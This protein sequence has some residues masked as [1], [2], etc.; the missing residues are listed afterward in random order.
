MYSINGIPLDNTTY[1]WSLLR[2]GTNPFAGIT[3]ERTE[4]KVPGYDGYFMGPSTRSEKIIVLRV[5][6]P[7]AGLEPL[8]ALVD[9]QSGVLSRTEDPSRVAAF[10]LSSALPD[11]EFPED[12]TVYLTITLIVPGGAWRDSAAVLTGPTTITGPSQVVS[13]LP[14]I[15][16]PVRDMDVYIRGVFGEFVLTD[17]QGSS[18]RTT[19]AWSG[20]SGT[21]LLYVGATGQAFLANN[22]AP[23]TPVT[24]MSHKIDVSGG[25]GFKI[26]P[27]LNPSDPSDRVGRLTLTTLT[28]TSVEFRTRARGA[29]AIQ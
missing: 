10:E 20:S 16:A 23:W 27:Y 8:M 4:V 12:H 26:T 11:G 17:S 28:Q 13:V 21:G 6:T 18:L 24:D 3:R 7:Q 9:T 15:S 2:K 1:G 19:S 25:G 5:K 29:Y 14:G 22:A